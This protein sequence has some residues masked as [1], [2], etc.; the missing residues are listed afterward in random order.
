MSTS[1]EVLKS[2]TAEEW[3]KVSMEVLRMKCNEFS[4]RAGKKAVMIKNLIKYFS[5]QGDTVVYPIAHHAAH[6][7]SF[8]IEPSMNNLS[9][10]EST[11]VNNLVAAQSIDSLSPT[12]TNS[13]SEL[14]LVLREL[15]AL[16]SE[17]TSIKLSQQES[18]RRI[19]ATANNNNNG[20]GEMAEP[21]GL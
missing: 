7:I 19:A 13:T 10:P 9:Q 15:H 11:A 16:Q 21:P 18:S 6:D 12:T 17:V 3:K 1:N 14:G 8:T 20:S 5:S 2:F 4:L